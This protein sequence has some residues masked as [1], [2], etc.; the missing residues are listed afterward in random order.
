[1]SQKARLQHLLGSL[2]FVTHHD[3]EVFFSLLGICRETVLSLCIR[4]SLV[5]VT[6]I[7][8]AQFSANWEFVTELLTLL[9]EVLGNLSRFPFPSPPP[10]LFSH[11]ESLVFVTLLFMIASVLGNLSRFFLK[12]FEVA[13]KRLTFAPGCDLKP[14]TLKLFY[15]L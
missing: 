10:C 13:R 1:M 4:V 15:C 14:L 8:T 5:F 7:S 2:E 11:W 9:Y 6:D 12:Y 3:F